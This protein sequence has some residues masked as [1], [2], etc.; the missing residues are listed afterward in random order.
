MSRIPDEVWENMTTEDPSYTEESEEEPPARSRTSNPS[1]FVPHEL[2]NELL[3]IN[4]LTQNQLNYLYNKYYDEIQ[5][6]KY[7]DVT[8]DEIIPILI[9]MH[10]NGVEQFIDIDPNSESHDIDQGSIKSSISDT[11]LYTTGSG[12]KIENVE[13]INVKL[14]YF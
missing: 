12:L 8:P 14:G 7:K 4:N 10:N 2:D 1:E 3:D 5:E 11:K 9:N 6:I 13:S